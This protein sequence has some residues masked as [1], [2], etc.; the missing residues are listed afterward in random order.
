MTESVPRTVFESLL[1]SLMAARKENA[2][3]QE[4]LEALEAHVKALERVTLPI[5][6]FGPVLNEHPIYSPTKE[7]EQAIQEVVEK[8]RAKIR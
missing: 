4:R 7:D 2:D 1:D 5:T 6:P 8:L 3:L